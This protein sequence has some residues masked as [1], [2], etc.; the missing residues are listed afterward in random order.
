MYFVTNEIESQR[1]EKSSRA[2]YVARAENFLNLLGLL[3]VKKIA[4]K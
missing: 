3:T 1:M 4:L 2:K